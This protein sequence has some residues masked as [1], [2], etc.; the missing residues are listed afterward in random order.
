MIIELTVRLKIEAEHAHYA[1]KL[2][3]LWL[4][5]AEDDDRLIEYGVVGAEEA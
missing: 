4:R 3:D 5:S 1:E 2:L